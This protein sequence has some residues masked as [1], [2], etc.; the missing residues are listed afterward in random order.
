M[1]RI[2]ISKNVMENEIFDWVSWLH[3]ILKHIFIE[4]L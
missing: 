4:E 3:N 2:A 1:K